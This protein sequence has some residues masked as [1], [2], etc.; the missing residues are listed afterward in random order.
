MSDKKKTTMLDLSGSPEFNSIAAVD[1][2]NVIK[3]RQGGNKDIRDTLDWAGLLSGPFEPVGIG[4]DILSGLISLSKGDYE[5]AG[6]SGTAAIPGLGLLSST[7]KVANLRK[8]DLYAARKQ[9][10]FVESLRG[11]HRK[12]YVSK[13]FAKRNPDLSIPTVD[14]KV[15]GVTTDINKLKNINPLD[16]EEALS[17]IKSQKRNMKSMSEIKDYKDYM[18]IGE[19]N[20]IYREIDNKF[21]PAINVLNDIIKAR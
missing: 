13:D 5:R 20:E 2:L 1:A 8:G 16:A 7:K 15:F 3:N 11:K 4:A 14:G 9:D 19:L 6:W 12:E 18:G 10:E 17:A 21:A